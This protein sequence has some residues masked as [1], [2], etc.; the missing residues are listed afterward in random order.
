MIRIAGVTVND[1]VQARFALPVIKGIGKSNVKKILDELNI[2]HTTPLKDV[3]EQEINKLRNF[4]ENNYLVES[5]LKRKNLGDIKRLIDISTYRGTRHK[6]GLPV[7]GQTTKT[8][9]RTRRGNVRRTA[10]SG[11]AKAS[12]KT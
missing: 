6:N 8:N 11:R 5:D 10:G 12:D 2:K 3:E 7:R 9:S 1:K 4:I